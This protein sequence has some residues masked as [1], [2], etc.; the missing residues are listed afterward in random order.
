M[1]TA[2]YRWYETANFCRKPERDVAGRDLRSRH[3]LALLA[4]KAVPGHRRG[5]GFE[6][7]ES[8]LAQHAAPRRLPR[9]SRR[10]PAA[11]LVT[12]RSWTTASSGRE[13]PDAR[14]AT[15]RAAA[16]GRPCRPRRST[17]PHSSGLERLGLAVRAAGSVETL[18]LTERGVCSVAES[19]P[20]Y[21]PEVPATDA[22]GDQMTLRELSLRQQR[23]PAPRRR[24]VR[25]DRAAGRLEA[26]V[27]IGDVASPRR[28]CAASSRRSRPSGCS[29]IRTRPP[30]ACRPR[31]GYRVFA[32]S[33]SSR[34]GAPAARVPARPSPGRTE[35]DPALQATTEMLSQ[36]TRLLAL[37][38]AP[39]LEATTVKHVEVLLLQPA[40]RDGP[41]DHLGRRGDEARLAVRR[42]GRPGL[43]AGRAST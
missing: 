35:I 1:T 8:S 21:S 36:V 19:R 29:R 33:C 18:A 28:P 27:E 41:R 10:R 12:S 14:P 15:R 38:S 9:S 7:R 20:S 5:R 23:D 13:R 3:N 43:A 24:G 31:R 17:R 30:A 26:L 25:G 22:A 16:S 39:P 37:V 42:A 11:R 32:A 34:L 40:G 6:N 4:R 2:G